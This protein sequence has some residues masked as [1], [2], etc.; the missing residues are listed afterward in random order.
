MNTLAMT[1]K[2]KEAGVS[3]TQARAHVEVLQDAMNGLAT[4]ADLL[5][6]VAELQKS[7]LRLEALVSETKAALAW[8]SVGA[9]VAMTAIFSI[10]SKW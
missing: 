9:V 3:E 7:M 4:K 10:I 2:L 8:Q 1:D 6:A 5:E